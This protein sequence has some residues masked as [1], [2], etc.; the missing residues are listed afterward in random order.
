VSLTGLQKIEICQIKLSNSSF[1]Y[2]VV[3]IAPLVLLL[4]KTGSGSVIQTKL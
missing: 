3:I 1:N 4:V 2:L